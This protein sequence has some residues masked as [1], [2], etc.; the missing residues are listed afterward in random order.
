[1]RLGHNNSRG[2]WFQFSIK[3]VLILTLAVA[4]FSAGKLSEQRRARDAERRARAEA[5]RARRAAER[6]F[7]Q[8]QAAVEQLSIQQ[9]RIAEPR[10]TVNKR[11]SGA[12]P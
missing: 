12:E 10:S 2:H 5:E 9:S 7:R 3:A 1:M 4:A 11:P 6:S 8:A